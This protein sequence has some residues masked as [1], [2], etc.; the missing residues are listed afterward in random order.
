MVPLSTASSCLLSTVAV[1]AC[2]Q[3]PRLHQRCIIP[4]FGGLFQEESTA[5]AL[6]KLS[7]QHGRWQEVMNEK[8]V[9][10]SVYHL[11]KTA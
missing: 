10:S 4:R 1:S 8:R 7:C 6:Q 3:I 5:S 2:F 9:D 11:F